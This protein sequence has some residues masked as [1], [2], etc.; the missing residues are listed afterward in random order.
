MNITSQE[1]LTLFL[2]FCLLGLFL[3]I[4]IFLRAKI[5]L[6]QRLFLPASIIGGFLLLSL[7]VLGISPFPKEIIDCWRIFPGILINIVFAGLFLGVEIPSLK[8]IWQQGGPQLCYGW[9]VGAGLPMV[10]LLLTFFLINPLFKVP[11]FFGCLLEIGFSGGHGTAAG[12]SEAFN[13]LGYPEGLDLGLMS[14][15]MGIISA[16]V[17]GMLLINI[18]V[19]KKIISQKEMVLEDKIYQTGKEPAAHHTIFSQIIDSFALHM[20]L[21]GISVLIGWALL[22]GIQKLSASM[23][24]D[25]FKSF[26]LFPMAMVGGLVVQKIASSMNLNNYL[27]RATFERIIGLSLDFLVIS[28]IAS[29]RI[30][31]FLENFF[32]FMILIIV[33]LAWVILATWIIAPRI[34][35]DFWFERAITE[36]GMQTGVTAIGLMLLRVVDPNFKTPAASSF[37]F[38]QMVYE[39][40]LGGGF[41]TAA[42]PILIVEYGF[43]VTFLIILSTIIFFISLSI[44]A[45][46]WHKPKF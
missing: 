19:R 29:L 20:A 3:V 5:K 33:G 14:A 1:V 15:T 7:S 2:S 43:W 46:W 13:K 8:K 22:K 40:F 18:A 12:M 38:K 9:L 26:P 28:A 37:G 27:D 11:L 35:E 31:V 4:G 6:L 23:Q 21:I 17:F 16:V 32:P 24:P 41:I 30:E 42:T 36:Y 34:F 25:L 45:G 39:P 10:G 44:I